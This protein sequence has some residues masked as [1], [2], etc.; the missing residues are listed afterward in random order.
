MKNV[1]E[2]RT[3]HRNDMFVFSSDIMFVPIS[4]TNPFITDLHFFGRIFFFYKLKFVWKIDIWF[5]LFLV[6]FTEL[7]LD[8]AIIWL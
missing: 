7:L 4:Q 2:N 3:I 1:K 5:I 6:E 8:A